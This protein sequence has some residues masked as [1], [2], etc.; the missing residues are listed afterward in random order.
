M[1]SRCT[2]LL[3]IALAASAAPSHAARDS[4][5]PA[6]ATG[7]CVSAS[8]V[9]IAEI[10][11]DATGDDTGREFVELFNPTASAVSLA[12]V[13]LEAGD[14]AGPG[15][16]TLR[17]TGGGN[18]SVAA[19][20]RFVIGGA[21]VS[22]APNAVASLDLQNG[23]DAVR[24]RWP[25]GSIEVVGYGALTD[26]EYFCGAPAADV[27]SGQSLAREP[28]GADRGS[29]ALDFVVADPTPGRPNQVAFD[30][31]I[32]RG[33]LAIDPAQPAPSA[34]AR[35]S[36]L[37]LNRGTRALAAREITLIATVD[38][39]SACAAAGPPL[40]ALDSARVALDLAGLD[41]GV[42]IVGVRAMLAGDERPENDADSIRVR[43][44]SGPLAITEIQFHPA[45][46]EGEWIEVRARGPDAV[47]LER[48]TL[49]DRNGHPAALPSAIVLAPDSLALLAE[50]RAALIA[51]YPG[52]DSLRVLE[53]SPWAALN[54]SDDSTG[55]ADAVVVR[56]SDGTPCDRVDYSAR[57]IAAGVPLELGPLGW[58]AD[59]D[60]GG[61]PLQ[62]PR[63]PP[64]LATRFELAP[65][66]VRAGLSSRLRWALPWARGTLAVEI[67]DLTGRR[68][69]RLPE[70]LI[71]ARGERAIEGLPGP[72]VYLLAIAA[73]SEN[74]AR[75]IR[76]TRT[77]RVEGPAR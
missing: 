7:S 22:P 72:G 69:A 31:A 11:Y 52:L 41:A 8:G 27:P 68:I 71:G 15:R 1:P 50:D 20:S 67:F 36:A 30:A 48:F 21:L 39:D 44:G 3:A 51:H 55:I 61:T 49:S 26:V 14:G 65:R 37:L 25:D 5:S 23:P 19:S 18:D 24:L 47:A 28:D 73:R 75:L 38:G 56:E 12:G 6:A 59:S 58:G 17:W 35:L 32:S 64:G 54:N 60:P 34:P 16:W 29:N 40:G 53:V 74:G 63:A 9:R 2:A 62:P 76:E 33:S 43:A 45:G 42:H 77:L 4:A 57:G 46:G 66:R 13:R 10:L 70:A